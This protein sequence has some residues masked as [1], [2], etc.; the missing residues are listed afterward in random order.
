M[1][2]SIYNKLYIG[3]GYYSQKII[4][5]LKRLMNY[6]YES[7][8][9]IIQSISI[10]LFCLQINYHKYL[11]YIIT[12][13]GKL[14]FGVYLAHVNQLVIKNIFH[15]V[16]RNDPSNLTLSST[17]ILFLVKGVKIFFICIFI[18][19]L[20]N[21]LFVF[22]RIISICIFLEKMIFKIFG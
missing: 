1:Q 12:F 11:A 21:L 6:S 10:T 16:F 15:K 19:Y 18:D 14:T 4:E 13:C 2:I 17:I 7:L 5:V 8:T 20:R 22:L 9:T 3:N